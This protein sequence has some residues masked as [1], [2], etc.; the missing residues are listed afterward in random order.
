MAGVHNQSKGVDQ[1]STEKQASLGAL[2]KKTNQYG[3][4]YTGIIEI[5]GMPKINI[6]VFPNR[7]KNEEKSLKLPDYRIYESKP[8]GSAV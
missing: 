6:V 5:P 3:D 8:K 4:F 2:W 1:V 7:F